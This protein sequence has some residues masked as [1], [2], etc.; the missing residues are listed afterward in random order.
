MNQPQLSHIRSIDGP[1]LITGHTGF[2]GTWMTLLLENLG[3]E[4][5]G[6]SLKPEL[7]SLYERLG[8]QAVINEKFVDIRDSVAVSGFINQTKRSRKK[9]HTHTH[10]FVTCQSTLQSQQMLT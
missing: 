10:W 8:R 6:L 5:V 3:M 7:G 9:T 1:V 2:K 4:V